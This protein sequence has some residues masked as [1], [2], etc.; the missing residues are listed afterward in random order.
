MD[1]IRVCAVLGIIGGLMYTQFAYAADTLP[2]EIRRSLDKQF[3]GWRFPVLGP[4]IKQCNAP[5]TLW[6]HGDFDGDGLPDYAME[7]VYRDELIVVAR[8]AN[9]SQQVLTKSSVANGGTQVDQALDVLPEG[10]RIGDGPT[11]AH[12]AVVRLDCSGP[13]TVTYF[14]VRA[15]KWHSD[16]QV[17]E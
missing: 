2:M 15:G 3:P 13:A 6:V 14:S 17:T 11:Y 9:G 7:L 5:S 8:L 4:Q 12:D 16:V 1:N 10:E